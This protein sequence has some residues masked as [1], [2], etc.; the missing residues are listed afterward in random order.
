MIAPAI[1]ERS[2]DPLTCVSVGI[3]AWNEEEAIEAA[4]QSLWGQT[5]FAEI[6]RRGL[7]SEILCLANGCTDRT[8]QIAR[9]FFDSLQ[10]DPRASSVSCRVIEVHERGKNNSWNLFTHSFSALNAS[11]LFL[12]DADIVIQG[13]ET[14][15]NM[16]CALER[17]STASVAVDRPLKDI[18][19]SSRPSFTHRISIAASGMTRTAAAQVTGQLYC[20]RSQIARQIHLPR[21]L[22][23]C[24]DGFIKALVCTDFLTSELCP[25][26]VVLAD[27]AAHVFQSYR[28]PA[29]VI[30]NQKRQMIGQTIVHIL[31]DK[32]LKELPLSD[33]LNLASAI[34][35]R[36]S[37]DRDWLKRLIAQHLREVRYFWRLFPNLLRFRFERWSALPPADRITHFPSV[38]VAYVIVLLASRMAFRF[39]KQGS[40]NYWPDTRS[41]GLK[42]L[43]PVGSVRTSSERFLTTSIHPEG[44]LRM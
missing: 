7:R 24:E 12:M 2:H 38:V 39:L 42:K 8:V 33:R 29:D 43:L 32:H 30:R 17:D 27:D 35:A 1:I 31:V 19:L 5:I 41:P 23:A 3:I 11:A 36:E 6:A 44:T 26:R 4:L 37:S 40:I 16:Y 20:I 22:A 10:D 25:G 15:W 9:N 28:R 21:D 14:F 34:R 13:E 18:A